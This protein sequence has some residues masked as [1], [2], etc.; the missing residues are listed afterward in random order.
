M[1]FIKVP[2]LD[3]FI[4]REQT[5]C[6]FDLIKNTPKN[7]FIYFSSVILLPHPPPF[8][9]LVL[10]KLSEQSDIDVYIPLLSGCFEIA[11]DH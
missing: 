10:L 8:F 2:C 7:F 1:G 6:P 5:V 3:S 11:A 4:K 9:F